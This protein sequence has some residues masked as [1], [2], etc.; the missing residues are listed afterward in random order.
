MTRF[1]LTVVVLGGVLSACGTLQLDPTPTTKVVAPATT[2]DAI[3]TPIS[4]Q[5][6]TRLPEATPAGLTPIASASPLARTDCPVGF[7]TYRHAAA[8]LSVCAPGWLEARGGVDATGSPLVNLETPRG[9]AEP[10]VFVSVQTTLRATFPDP[11]QVA[12]FCSAGL[13]QSQTSG[14]EIRVTVAGLSAVGCHVVGE[15]NAVNGPLEMISLT[16]PLQGI[17]GTSYLNVLL[18]WRTQS[19]GAKALAAAILATVALGP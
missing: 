15:P 16:A 13:V 14:E 10:E 17:S 4:A 9:S 5:P 7:A 1:M 2:P 12:M 18:T 8:A 19:V 3:G 6:V 11:S